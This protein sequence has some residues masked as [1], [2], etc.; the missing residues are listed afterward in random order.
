MNFQQKSRAAE[1]QFQIVTGEDDPILDFRLLPES[2]AL[3]ER[4]RSAA[5]EENQSRRYKYR[6]TLSKLAPR[7]LARNREGDAVFFCVNQSD[8]KGVKKVNMKAARCLV[9]D[10]DGAPLPK[11]WH[12]EPHL[13]VET[14]PNRYQVFWAIK[15]TTDFDLYENIALRLA[16]HYDGDKSVCDV[17]RI[18]RVAGFLHQKKEKAF[19]ST[20]HS[21]VDPTEIERLSLSAFAWLPEVVKDSGSAKSGKRTESSDAGESAARPGSI[22]KVLA[23]EILE[24]L[25]PTDF[26]SNDAWEELAMSLHDAC[27]GNA[28]VRDAFLEWCSRDPNYADEVFWAKNYSRWG[29]FRTDKPIRKTSRTLHYICQQHGVPQKIILKLKRAETWFEDLPDYD[30]EFES[31]PQTMAYNELHLPEMLDFAEQELISAA[32]PLYQINGRLV[33][34][35][36]LDSDKSDQGIR[37]REG[38]LITADVSATRLREYLVANVNFHKAVRAKT[39]KGK[40]PKHKSPSEHRQIEVPFAPPQTLANALLARSDKWEFPILRGIIEAPT[41]RNDGTLITEPGYD[42]SSGLLLATNGVRYPPIGDNPTREDALRALAMLKRPFKDFP[43]VGDD[44]GVGKSPSQSVI[45]SAVLTTLVRRTLPSAPLH[46]TDAPTP[47]TGKSLMLDVVSLIAIGRQSAAI[48]QGANEEEDQ[49]R[50][51]SLLLQGDAICM[52]DNVTRPIEGNA[53]CSI[54]TQPIWQSR[55][56]SES[57]NVAVSTN[58]TFLASGNNL[59]FN[60]DMTRRAIVCR[61]DARTEHPERRR[62]DIDLKAVVPKR[63]GKLVAAGLTVLRAYIVAG[64]PG[65]KD[66]EPFGGFEEWSNLVRGSLV[67][68]GEPDPCQTR[69]FILQDDPDRADLFVLMQAMTALGTEPKTAR[70]LIAAGTD[71]AHSEN[72]DTALQ[73]AIEA[74]AKNATPKSLGNYLRGKEGRIVGGLQLQGQANKKTKVW[75]YRI[76][77][78]DGRA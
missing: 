18:F 9:L 70:E 19:R 53:L 24:C 43:F 44:S 67:W 38:A 75:R 11:S 14:S 61:I 25:D 29:S 63:R 50:L 45:L 56:L 73:D 3:L 58:V 52:I 36:R 42:E 51:F 37:R 22:R 13:V 55:V 64:R 1:L 74:V 32:A 71:A 17:T 72:A 34:P 60:G 49:K 30:G 31:D 12:I 77:K 76:R 7:L 48:S 10:L 41:L 47:G 57:R 21:S 62:F 68:L 20:I 69:E 35:V 16:H 26:A 65:A 27:G 33:H 6:N 46:A 8:G 5:P 4:L 40:K 54:L 2:P 28:E 39:S 15:K 66:L 78:A 23:A 59:R